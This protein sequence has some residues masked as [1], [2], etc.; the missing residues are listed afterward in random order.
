M[1]G[2]TKGPWGKDRYGAIFGANGEQVLFEGMAM[3]GISTPTTRANR[4]LVCAAPDL[5]EAL[6]NLENDNGQIPSGAWDLVCSAI[7]KAR[8]HITIPATQSAIDAASQEEEEK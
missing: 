1:I 2:I 7:A 6:E 8:G 5:L 4:D 3:S